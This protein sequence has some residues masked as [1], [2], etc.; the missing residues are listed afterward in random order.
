MLQASVVLPSGTANLLRIEMS[1]T[2]S[3]NLSL[4]SGT[5]DITQP[6]PSGYNRF[7]IDNASGTKWFD[8]MSKVSAH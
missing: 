7:N 1:T 2:S 6:T 5:I 3:N 4:T 8:L